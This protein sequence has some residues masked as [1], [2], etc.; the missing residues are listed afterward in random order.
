MVGLKIELLKIAKSKLLWLGFALLM[1]FPL[2]LIIFIRSRF[3]DR[4][5]LDITVY[6]LV[7]IVDSS[8]LF[9]VASMFSGL[10]F[11]GEFQ[12]KT[13]RYI[14]IRPI[15]LGK[16]FLNK[17]VAV[18]LYVSLLLLATIVLCTLL[19]CLLWEPLPMHG[20]GELILTRPALRFFL[21]I[22]SALV[23]SF[24]LISLTTF[25]SVLLKSQVTVVVLT[26]LT[27]LIFFITANI[28]PLIHMA[29][30]IDF[31]HN[32]LNPIG[33][34]QLKMS[35]I[36]LNYLILAVESLLVLAATFFIVKRSDIKV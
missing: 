34:E 6:T 10:I 2:A 12:Y 5:A 15:S 18:W 14:L 29:L 21:L 11:A 30:P 27:Y 16:L 28:Y 25:Y 19:N 36:L 35:S 9:I 1:A 24:F 23:I 13:L 32:F 31:R 22:C 20:K 17:V 26:V 8:A 7:T 3:A 4:T 33:E